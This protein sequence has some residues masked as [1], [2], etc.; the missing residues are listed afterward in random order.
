VAAFVSSE[1]A[2]ASG[3]LWKEWGQ[4]SK[5]LEDPAAKERLWKELAARMPKIK[6]TLGEVA[7]HLDHI[8]KVAGPDHLGLG[9]DYDGNDAWPEGLEDVAGY[10]RL[11]AE[12]LRRGWSDSDLAKLANG[13]LLRVLRKAEEVSA[14]LRKERP[15]SIA[16]IKGLDGA[17]AIVKP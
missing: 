17:K 10:P 13:N 1:F 8:R 7:D 3:P 12:L 14:R 5:G 6:V 11:F 4:R 2:K 9:G 16:T 15:A